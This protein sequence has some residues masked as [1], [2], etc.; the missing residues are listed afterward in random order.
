MGRVQVER[1]ILK[2]KINPF[3]PEWRSQRVLCM[4][5]SSMEVSGLATHLNTTAGQWE[6]LGS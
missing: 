5:T 4:P 3:P 1:A 6:L 2:L